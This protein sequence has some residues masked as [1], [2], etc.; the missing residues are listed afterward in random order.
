LKELDLAI[1]TAKGAVDLINSKFSTNIG[2]KSQISRDIKTQADYET[3][4]Y[5]IKRLSKTGINIISEENFSQKF[6]LNDNQ[7]IIDPIDGTFNL[8]RR[9]P[10][11][12]VSI[13]LWDQG[14]P[15]LGV[16]NSISTND[17]YYACINGGAYKNNEKINV[18]SVNDISQAVLATGFP[19]GL[20]LSDKKANKFINN[21]KKYKKIRMLGSASM[22]LAY[23]ANGSFDVYQEDDIFIWDVAAGLSIVS[24]AGGFYSIKNGSSEYKFRIK[25]SNV[26][27]KN[28]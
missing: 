9:F 12:A 10:I 3:N 21:I 17:I 19:S 5:I 16:I 2:V 25:A 24:E 23:V 22:M 6:N 26:L 18:S 4:D 28:K 20:N 7:W 14:I 13:S 8:F 1:K 27:L 15:I 11:N